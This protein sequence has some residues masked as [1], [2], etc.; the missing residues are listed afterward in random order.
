MITKEEFNL[1][2]R[3]A[4]PNTKHFNGID[5]RQLKG[6]L[7]TDQSIKLPIRDVQGQVPEGMV[8]LWP[9]ELAAEIE[10]FA[11]A[12]R[13]DEAINQVLKGADSMTQLWKMLVLSLPRWTVVNVIGS[14]ILGV[15]AGSNPLA[16]PK[17]AVQVIPDLLRLHG[18][19]KSGKIGTFSKKLIDIGGET[20]TMEEFI[21]QAVLDRVANSARTLIEVVSPLQMAK[22]VGEMSFLAKAI[23][24]PHPIMKPWAYWFKMNAFVEDLFRVLVWADL[25]NQGNAR[26]VA[27]NQVAKYMFD[28]GDLSYVEKKFGT[29]VWPFYR[30]MRNNAALQLKLTLEK[31]AYASAYP[32]LLNALEEAFEDEAQL[33]THLQ[34]RWLRDQLAIQVASAPGEASFLSL[35]TLTPAQELFDVGQAVMGREGI[36]S[37]MQWLMGGLNPMLKAMPEIAAGREIFTR[38]DI[39]PPEEGGAITYPEWLGRQFGAI[40]EAA[41]IYDA[42]R[43]KAD[44]DEVDVLGGIM[45]TLVGGRFQKREV[46]SLIKQKRFE[47]GESATRLRFAIRRAVEAGDTER[48]RALSLEYVSM[49]R[50]LWDIGLH[51]LV[52]DVLKKLYRRE[53]WKKRN[54][55]NLAG[56]LPNVGG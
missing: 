9:E 25:R 10:N 46:E 6:D 26:L 18:L 38:R 42:F 53:D 14:S 7:I 33:P 45:R 50:L 51:E 19:T 24:K 47:A 56:S 15:L 21:K 49:H 2:A 32:K 54:P 35:G 5:M 41:N 48:A 17:I 16:W 11:K 12:F 29:R 22:D 40:P 20:L 43:G 23:V 44:D 39:G 36:E 8:Q 4:A 3:G 34:P 13:G 30:W 1:L 55:P 28:Y 27:G 52:P 31:P 37:A